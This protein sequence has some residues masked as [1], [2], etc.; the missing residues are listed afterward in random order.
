MVT[1]TCAVKRQAQDST[2]NVPTELRVVLQHT[3]GE[4][5]S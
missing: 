5:I 2:F 3:S 1:L 4:S